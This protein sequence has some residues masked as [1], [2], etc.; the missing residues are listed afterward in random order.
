M[1]YGRSG[2]DLN[3]YISGHVSVLTKGPCI[4]IPDHLIRT[5]NSSLAVPHCFSLLG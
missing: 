3:Q 5:C 2:S 1:Q 4:Y